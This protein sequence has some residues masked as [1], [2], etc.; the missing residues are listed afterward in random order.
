MVKKEKMVRTILILTSIVKK[1]GES[2]M[3]RAKSLQRFWAFL[4]VFVL[5]ATTLGNDS[6]TVNA[7]EVESATE[8]SSAS[9]S[10][11][12]EKKTVEET[13]AAS[14][15]SDEKA[16]VPEGTQKSEEGKA[17]EPETASE[18]NEESTKSGTESESAAVTSEE[19]TE[20]EEIETETVTETST[21]V[22]SDEEEKDSFTVSFEVGDG[23][24][25]KV[26]GESVSLVEDIEA[27]TNVEFHV[28]ASDGY[29]IKKVTA[30]G[31]EL[32]TS[33]GTYQLENVQEDMT[34]SVSTERN[35][36]RML[37]RDILLANTEETVKVRVS[38]ADG[39]NGTV[40][41]PVGEIKEHAPVFDGYSFVEARVDDDVIQFAGVYENYVYYSAGETDAGTILE[42]NKEIVLYYESDSM[43]VEVTYTT[44][45]GNA[46]SAAGGTVTGPVSVKRNSALTFRV[47]VNRGYEIDNVKING[48]MPL[49][50]TKVADNK[51]DYTIQNV[52]KTQNV[53]VTFKK[54][55]S[56]KLTYN[57]SKIMQG[58]ITSPGNNSTFTG[59][60]PL[61]L[62]LVSDSGHQDGEG[63]WT[64]W[65]LNNLQVNGVFINVP[66]SYETNAEA[67]TILPSGTKV[68]VKLTKID[69]ERIS[70]GSGRSQNFNKYTYTITISDVY[71]DIDI[72]SG[73]FKSN[74]RPEII[75]K[76]LEGIEGDRLY[77]LDANGNLFK[78]GTIN[79]VYK[80][81]NSGGNEF[82]FNVKPGYDGKDIKL[83]GTGM[84]GIEIKEG[85]YTKDNKTYK[86]MFK[87]NW[88]SETNKQIFLSAEKAKY[89]VRYDLNG[90]TGEIADDD[91]Y[92]AFEGENNIVAVTYKVP[93][94]DGKIF[95]H[96][97][98]AGDNSG[99]YRQYSRFTINASTVRYANNKN[100]FVFKAVW[101]DI[102]KS[103]Y[104]NVRINYLL[105]KEEGGYLV[106]YSYS[107]SALAEKA[108][109]KLCTDK[110]KYPDYL[111][112]D[113]RSNVVGFAS[114][115]DNDKI[116]INYY[117][118]LKRIDINGRKTWNVPK[119]TTDY[120]TVTINLYRDG[121]LY[122][123]T[124][125]TNGGTSYNFAN[126]PQYR[127][128]GGQYIYTVEETVP[129]GY[130]STVDAK[131]KFNITNTYTGKNPGDAPVDVEVTKLW[132]DDDNAV[133]LRPDSIT[134]NLTANGKATNNNAVLTKDN[135]WMYTF[136]D[137]NKY[138]TSGKEISYTVKETNVPEN[139]ESSQD[140]NIITNTLVGKGNITIP[141]AKK[142]ADADN[143][144]GIRP[145][146]VTVE[147][148]KN[149]NPYIPAK[150]ITL[151]S[152][153]NWN[154]RFPDLP[155]YEN[156]K[157]IE[158]SVKEG[159]VEGYTTKYAFVNDGFILTNTH[160]PDEITIEGR[161]TWLDN[162]NAYGTRPE[163][164]TI[165]LQGSDG[166]VYSKEV[167]ASDGWSWTFSGLPKNKDGAEIEYKIKEAEAE[168]YR[169][170]T[171]NYD[172]IN[173]LTG[174]TG[175][176]GTKTWVDYSNAGGTRPQTL[177]LHL[178]ADGTEL[179]D[180]VPVWSNTDGNVWS[181]SYNDL[182]KYTDEGVLINYSVVEEKLPDYSQTGKDGNNFVNTVKDDERT[183]TSVEG[184]KTWEDYSNAE[185]TRPT[186]KEFN[187][188]LLA[189]GS[190]VDKA[191]VWSNTNGNIWNYRY[192]NLPIY[193]SDG[194][195]IKYTVTETIPDGY[196]RTDSRDSRDLVNKLTD[197]S[198]TLTTVN[199]TKVWEDYSNVTK[200]RPDD[201]ILN[202]YAD[203]EKLEN[204]TPD[205][206]KD[207]N[208]WSYSYTGLKKYSDE[209]KV[210]LY[211]VEEEV[212]SNYT[213][214]AN[215][216]G[217]FV[218]TLI[219]GEKT[220]TE[221]SGTKTWVDYSNAGNTRPENLE[222]HLYA[223]DI[224]VMD[225]VPVWTKEGNV[226][227]YRYSRLKKYTENGS[228][229]VY[230]VEE[231]V[232]ENYTQT[233]NAENSFENTVKEGTATQTTVSGTKT[234]VDYSNAGGTRPENLELH[235]YADDMEVM[236]V[237]PVWTKEGNVWS[238]S[239]TGLKKFT[240]DGKPITYRVEETVPENYTQTKK[241]ENSFENKVKDGA[242]TQITVRG[243]KTWVDYSNAGKTR[244]ENLELHLY[245]DDM[246]VM[247]AAPVWTKEGNVWS[248]SYTGLKKF[249]EDGKPITY[250]VEETVP[251]N[252]TQTKNVENSFENKVKDGIATQ[253]TVSGTK[254]WV[255]YSN[256]GGTRPQTL[257]LHLFAD[258]TEIVDAV[259][260]WSNTDGNVW[261]YSYNDLQKYTDDGVLIVYTVEEEKLQDYSQTGKA[262]NNFENTVNDDERTLKS[263]EGTKTWEDYSNVEGTRPSAE[264][265]SLILLADGTPVEKTPVW[266]NTDGNKWNYRF[267]DLPIYT[268]DGKEIVYT[269]M[270]SVPDGYVRTDSGE[271]ND[272]VNKLID[273]AK[274]LTTVNGTK[275]WVDYSNAGNTRPDDLVLNLYADGVKQE[276]ITPVW[277]KDGNVWSYSFEKLKRYTDDGQEITYTVEEV[278]PEG[279]EQEVSQDGR[280][281][282]NTV[283]ESDLTQITVQGT[284][285]WLDYDGGELP[286]SIT[287]R[288]LA[289]SEEIDQA[290]VDE[291]TGWSFEFKDLPR[292]MENGT[293]I[294]YEVVE[295]SINGYESHIDGDAENGFEVVNRYTGKNPEEDPVNILVTK[296][297]EDADNQDNIRPGSILVSLLADGKTVTEATITAENLW[298]YEFTDLE[299]YNTAGKE[300]EYSVNEA[301]VVGYSTVIDGF[302]I[303]NSHTPAAAP[304]P[305]EP[306]GGA[307]AAAAATAVLG[308]AF[309]PVQP[310]VGVLGEALPPE[311]GVL[312]ESK[313]PGTGDS[314]PIAGWS[315]LIMGAILTLG[316]TAKKRKKE[317]E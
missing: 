272:L 263:V 190:P 297:W 189:D 42:D 64:D 213:Q 313:G 110:D 30:D 295:D 153:N 61:V 269:V 175:L 80:A 249:T 256:A 173:T 85:S 309:A 261:N 119:G 262:D 27:G 232:P 212:P 74:K 115:N 199:G 165:I 88:S 50:G 290:V 258:G 223:N 3:K 315:F 69:S 107:V 19:G 192:D 244:P 285:T 94:L 160:T 308:E 268:S 187:L 210:I 102:G 166:N 54:I 284:K 116:D 63:T 163:S 208:V 38:G 312:G 182:Q 5:V 254:T 138:D 127:P 140:G 242:A 302:T 316:I 81:A 133:G 150:T 228:R 236:D 260:V 91:T 241:V 211:E 7:A 72:S 259:P 196:V 197:D 239:Y 146:S 283:I 109:I 306:A 169:S 147:L 247:D 21:E 278:I 220:W 149:G 99:V 152:G 177:T 203:G 45:V 277:E 39:N 90:G 60:K 226:W 168:G 36:L 274:T 314:A 32:G 176:S 181:Y 292:F 22:T 275:I 171:E 252:Y 130:V 67:T 106:D 191:P 231:T 305:D 201:L 230:R 174:T 20:T 46:Q 41:I 24:V 289:D 251:E 299:K 238:Y 56:Y 184:T 13:S 16:E 11:A 225:A 293:L 227:S 6:V 255:D 132:V 185:K 207:G 276:N 25:V 221:V 120:P 158:Y 288:L 154:G 303:T 26:N 134:V 84:D 193:T 167:T 86:Y 35:K 143:Q 264:E 70:T 311:V 270:E 89:T 18:D 317:E 142:W 188:I 291:S 136:K 282:T 300:I 216:G 265:F 243:T 58:N 279:Y 205:W 92:T 304:T 180:A 164:I 281:F 68:N 52:T 111:Y 34:I 248:Y 95:D 83:S 79:D 100:E 131:N 76:Q 202:L 157:R 178:F 194:Q 28:E 77:G 137:V 222:L 93:T 101:A 66:S 195:E 286:E 98:L 108:A 55:T 235:L 33:A 267:T 161:K 40:N 129:D 280:I 294:I 218:N 17:D 186:A 14:S 2:G 198:R 87:V 139:Y 159:E 9:A 215:E 250:R 240:E 59:E 126:L 141:V 103:S 128:G 170:R 65:L 123:T 29:R 183:R 271:S 296:I 78:N 237:S 1:R 172:V 287:I 135:D 214:T 37:M 298:T 310:E 151:N 47:E 10:D 48:G 204:I 144:D 257:T 209:G 219:D 124:T 156:G 266:N 145:E 148:L 51:W 75:I 53:I 245:A 114:N 217:M 44:Q 71:E 200:S 233:K 234:W 82:Y 179:T 121:T 118:D 301:D 273:D 307:P 104:A 122:R 73:N 162:D 117:F 125:I 43:K 57:N 229:I 23:A 246:E 112:N 8:V 224:E 105:E 253:T 49:T 97:E 113:Q 206:T 62:T 96:W 4:L 31:S 155:E 15:D 12:N